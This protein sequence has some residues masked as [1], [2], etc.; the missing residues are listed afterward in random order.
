MKKIPV[1]LAF[2][3]TASSVFGQKY[4]VTPAIRTEASITVDGVVD[5][6]A[7]AAAPLITGLIEMRPTPGRVEENRN[8]S[9]L[10][11]LYDNSA[12][13]FGGTLYEESKDSIAQQLVGR[14]VI[15]INDFVGVVFDTYQDK[16]LVVLRGSVPTQEQKQRAEQIARENA[17]GYRID[18]Q[19][20]VAP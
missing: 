17:T 7:W 1:L 12:V 5:E 11:L 4:P 19:L 16:K 2:L 8:R 3:A 6:T 18:N 9:E 13:Y 15:G 20:V 14:D 10:R